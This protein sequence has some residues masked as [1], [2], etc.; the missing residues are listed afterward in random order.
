MKTILLLL[1]LASCA[2]DDDKIPSCSDLGLVGNPADCSNEGVCIWSGKACCYYPRPGYELDP[3]C[4][5]P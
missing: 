2:D 4:E 5:A 3:R 1:A